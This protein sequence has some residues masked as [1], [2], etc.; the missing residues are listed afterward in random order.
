MRSFALV[1]LAAL[2]VGASLAGC[3]TQGPAPAPGTTEAVLG[4]W[5]YVGKKLVD[6]AED[7]PEDKYGY[8]PS[9]EVRS[10]GEHLLHIAGTNYFI[11]RSARG[12]A[13]GEELSH[14][15]Y[16]TKADIAAVLKQ[17]FA[18]GA[19]AI[20][21]TGDAGMSRTLKHPF[22]DR[23]ISQLGLWVMAVENAGEHYGSLVVYYRINGIV[24][25]VSRKPAP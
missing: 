22:A 25:P 15:K 8:R 16:K 10:F 24:P 21:Q 18:D 11:M 5:N 20:Q 9:P 23:T 14:E 3:Q 19:A 13:G 4:S 12:E 7:F 1:V 17:S 6:M 2:L